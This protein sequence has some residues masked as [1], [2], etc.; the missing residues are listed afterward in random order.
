[1]TRD[2]VFVRRRALQCLDGIVRLLQY[3]RTIVESI[4][5]VLS[6]QS[7]R[8]RSCVGLYTIYRIRLHVYFTM[9]AMHTVFIAQALRIKLQQFRFAE[10]L[11]VE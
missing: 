1:M 11:S 4:L 3:H 8:V 10:G 6:L 2:G 5:F 7:Q 9:R